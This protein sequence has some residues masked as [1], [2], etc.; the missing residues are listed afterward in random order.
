MQS[1]E[2]AFRA[3]QPFDH[4]LDE[5]DENRALWHAMAERAPL[6]DEA[7][8]RIEASDG[9]WRLLVLADDWCGDAVNTIPVIERLAQAANNLELRII[10]RDRYPELRDRHLT[11]GSR[12]IPIVVL[13]DESG[14][15]RGSWGPRPR[16]LQ[17][18]VLGELNRL[19]RTD[20]YRMVR[21]W[22]ARDRGASTAQEI[23]G[24]VKTAADAIPEGMRR[25]CGTR[26][27]A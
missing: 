19:S 7:A 14:T 11:N 9:C 16:Q 6:H 13:L 8:R 18:R 25:P 21:T 26:K 4:F 20:R 3:G 27:A 24:L 2:M 15:P 1:Y 5:A 22:Y 23:A 17:E 12:S 10:P